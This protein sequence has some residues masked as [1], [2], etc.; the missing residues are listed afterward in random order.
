VNYH[1]PGAAGDER[2]FARAAAQLSGF[3][4]FER[5]RNIAISFDP[6]R[7]MPRSA[8]PNIYRYYLE[9]SRGESELAH[10]HAATAIFSGEGGD[11][12]FYQSRAGFGAGDYLFRQ[13]RVRGLGSELFR[14]ALDG[15]R[16]ERVSV[17]NVL[18]KALAHAWLGRRWTLATEM[19]MFNKLMRREAI[20]AVKQDARWVHPHFQATGRV[21]SGKLWHAYPLVFPGNDYYDPLGLLD[22]V[23]RVA[24]LFSQ[25]VLESCLRIPVD[26]LT[27]GGWDRAIARRAFERDLPPEI[28]TRRGKGMPDEYVRR[29]LERNFSFVREMLLDGQLVRQQFIDRAQLEAMLS[30]DPTRAESGGTEI[31]DY[32]NAEA[33][34]RRF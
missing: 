15:A 31:Y 3:E 34:L 20:E 27:L 8:A 11:Q 32:L 25:P 30:G 10:E 22:D 33:W 9:N 23:E 21:P 1:S 19:G 5:E 26:V 6:L 28:V 24:P 29:V 4:L 16:L 13:G 12:L 14:I 17:W 18:A 2:A 7:H